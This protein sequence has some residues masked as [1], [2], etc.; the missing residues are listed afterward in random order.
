MVWPVALHPWLLCIR[1]PYPRSISIRNPLPYDCLSRC[2]I[3]TEMKLGYSHRQNIPDIPLVHRPA[4]QTYSANSRLML[5]SFSRNKVDGTWGTPRFDLWP[6]YAHTY[7]TAHKNSRV[8][9]EWMICKYNFMIKTEHQKFPLKNICATFL[10]IGG[11]NW[12]VVAL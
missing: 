1:E 5:D 4:R 2:Y 6:S 7:A 3:T 11:E 10:P 12:T 8:D 9:M